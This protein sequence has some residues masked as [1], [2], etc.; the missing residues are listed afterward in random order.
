[1]IEKLE[2]EGVHLK[3]D[4]KTKKYILRK[5]GALD[6]YLPNSVKESAHAEVSL[7]E[8]NNKSK[9]NCT[10]EVILYL[11]NETI[12]I[13]ETTINMFAAVDIVESKLK[14]KIQ[15]YKELHNSGKLRRRLFARFKR[16]SS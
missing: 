11:P 3:I 6:K 5:I 8:T 15:Q 1:M 4:E 13:K 16:R 2:I 12:N 7:K 9:K 10:C 14:H